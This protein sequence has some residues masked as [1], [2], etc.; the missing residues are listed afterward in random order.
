MPMS[1]VLRGKQRKLTREAIVME[2]R[3]DKEAKS[4]LV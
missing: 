1:I 4:R 3:A 2:M